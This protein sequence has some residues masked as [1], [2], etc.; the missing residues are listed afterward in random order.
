MS[1]RTSKT[2]YHYGV[3]YKDGNNPPKIIPVAN[4][5][6]AEQ[7][8]KIHNDS[9]PLFGDK[10]QAFKLKRKVTVITHVGEWEV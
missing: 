1:N 9:Q 4:E 7:Q 2:L 3:L 10:V 6:E 5:A 8:V